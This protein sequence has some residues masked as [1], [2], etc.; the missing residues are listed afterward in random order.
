[1]RYRI[2]KDDFAGRE[3]QYWTKGKWKQCDSG[4]HKEPRSG[5]EVNT[6]NSHMSAVV[7]MALHDMGCHHIMTCEKL[8]EQVRVFKISNG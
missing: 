2:I 3:V 8:D 5:F 6:F 4:G 1:M 7:F